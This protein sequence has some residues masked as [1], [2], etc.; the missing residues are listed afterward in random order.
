MLERGFADAE[1]SDAEPADI[2]FS[3]GNGAHPCGGTFRLRQ[4]IDPG[5]CLKSVRMIKCP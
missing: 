3:L 2:D 5:S 4:Y 1:P